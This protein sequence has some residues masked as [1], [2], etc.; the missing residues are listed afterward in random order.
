MPFF[1]KE[2]TLFLHI[3]KTGGSSIEEYL[4]K[5]YTPLNIYTFAHSKRPQSGQL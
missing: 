3:P 2:K 4:C 5:R 1:S